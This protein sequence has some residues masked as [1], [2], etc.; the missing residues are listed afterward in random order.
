MPRERRSAPSPFAQ[1]KDWCYLWDDY[2]HKTCCLT[3]DDDLIESEP[4]VFDCETCDL[5]CGL[6][7]LDD[8]NKEA[9]MLF[10]QMLSRLTMEH[11]G[12]AAA[13]LSRVIE[14]Y[15]ADDALDLLQRLSI[16]YDVLIPVAPPK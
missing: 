14:R 10:Q 1:L 3:A 4:A 13:V 11:P 15:S 8:A 6:H 16:I 7:D 12:L 5:G 9:W 2:K